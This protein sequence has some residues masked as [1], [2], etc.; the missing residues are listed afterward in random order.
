MNTAN[1][2]IVITAYN[3]GTP[4]KNLLES[5]NNI[6]TEKSIPLII[7]IDNK[8]TDDVNRI[9]DEFIWKHGKKKVIIHQEKKGLRAHFIWVGDQTEIYENV[10][11]LEDDL[12]V[13]PYVTEFVE[14]CIECFTTDKRITGVS[15]Y[16]PLLCEF[17]KCKFFQIED[18]YDNYFFQ[19]PYWGNVWFRDS[20]KEFKEW[21]KK[22]NYNPD[23]LPENV[24]RWNTTSFKKVYI[25]YL[26]EMNRYMV[27]P[28]VS[29]VTNMGETGLHSKSDFRQFQ[30]SLQLGKK[31][32]A[33]S[34]FDE[35][36]SIYDVFFEYLSDL[37]KKNNKDLQQY[38]FCTDIKGLRTKYYTE[39]VLT[40]RK[41][42][43]PVIS[44]SNEHRPQ[45]INAL[46]NNFGDGIYLAKSSDVVREKN[47]RRKRIV[48]DILCMNYCVG[49]RETLDCFIYSLKNKFLRR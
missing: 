43:N 33:L 29:Y 18:G 42:L 8:G 46:F 24:Q 2:A 34:S 13:S 22:Y 6:V 47:F 7:S 4:L 21:F 1:Y 10:L 5:L 39:Y 17:D 44:F 30:T 3:R 48:D 15:L 23:I 45:E 49:L 9:A 11:F 12:Y 26:A 19:H 14:K 35:S 27:Y 40:S 25:Q 28:R 32:L 20:W 16:N 31:K 36:Q 37:I 38:D 41:V